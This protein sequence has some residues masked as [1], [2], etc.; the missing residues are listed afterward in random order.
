MSLNNLLHQ[1]S[2]KQIFFQDVLS[3]IAAEY[4]YSPSSFQNGNQHNA[5]SENQGSAR[6]LYFAKINN[7][8]K[9]S[10]LTLFAEHYE[11]VLANPEGQDHQNIRQFMEHG[12]DA[13]TFD[14]E[15]LT[16]Q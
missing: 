1:L 16:K 2:A 13:V 12:W 15:V 14:N 11:A 9:E 5:A 4:S 3:F 8:N 7:L 10:T 6:V